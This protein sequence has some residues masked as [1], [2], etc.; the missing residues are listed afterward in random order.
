[1]SVVVTESPA[2]HFPFGKQREENGPKHVNSSSDTEDSLPF[3]NSVLDRE[4]RGK[5]KK[6]VCIRRRQSEGCENRNVH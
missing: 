6:K 5:G 3:P 4:G 1:V 2:L